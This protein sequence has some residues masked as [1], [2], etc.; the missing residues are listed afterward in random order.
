MNTRYSNTT[1]S[2][3][4][5]IPKAKEMATSG[6]E[7][8]L[9]LDL[10]AKWSRNRRVEFETVEFECESTLSQ[11]C[12]TSSFSSVTQLHNTV[13]CTIY[14]VTFIPYKRFNMRDHSN[15]NFTSIMI[16]ST[17]ALDLDVINF[18]Y[19]PASGYMW[20]IIAKANLRSLLQVP[21]LQ[22]T[23]ILVVFH[24]NNLLLT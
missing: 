17:N 8:K 11:Y 19:T 1:N 2:E 15:I 3:S 21:H 13:Y 24:K 12:M 16:M 9:L 7:F 6:C 4:G 10:I 18:S 23:T 14:W 5:S 22:Y 20:R